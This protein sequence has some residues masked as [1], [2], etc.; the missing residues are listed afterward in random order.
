L[1]ASIDGEDAPAPHASERAIDEDTAT[2]LQAMMAAT[3][4]HGTASRSF[5]SSDRGYRAFRLVPVA[6]KTGSLT[7]HKG[8]RRHLQK[9]PI[10][11]DGGRDYT[12]FVGFAPVHDPKIAIGVAMVNDEWTWYARALD[13]TKLT[14]R[15]Y[16]ELHPEDARAGGV[17]ASRRQSGAS[18]N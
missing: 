1:I 11:D 7:D 8:Y 16:F 5:S 18:A 10:P 15:H 17:V 14:L 4:E 3:V 12:W 9:D 13:I 2:A 6:G